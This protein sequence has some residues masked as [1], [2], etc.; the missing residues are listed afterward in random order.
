MLHV[1]SPI[2][3]LPSLHKA[4]LFTMTWAVGERCN[5]LQHKAAVKEA[6]SKKQ[7]V[8]HRAQPRVVRQPTY[9]PPSH[10]REETELESILP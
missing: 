4:L 3:I 1:I 8:W 10:N 6:R 7:E 9:H 2:A 5:S